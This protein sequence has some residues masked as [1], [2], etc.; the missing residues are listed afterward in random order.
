MLETKKKWKKK[1]ENGMDFCLVSH[2]EAH[3][4]GTN[5]RHTFIYPKFFHC[6]SK[7]HQPQ[8]HKPRF[9][10]PPIFP[11]PLTLD[12]QERL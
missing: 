7:A 1:G 2:L 5:P 4:F 3:Q 9:Q 8:R 11:S 6:S 10:P 12:T